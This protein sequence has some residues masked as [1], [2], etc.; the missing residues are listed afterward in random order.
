MKS[1]KIKSVKSLGINPTID[2]EV[3]HPDHN[4]YA[5]GVV[6]SNSHS[7]SYASLAATTVALKSKYPKEFLFSCL[8]MAKY[9]TKSGECITRISNELKYYGISILPPSL[10][11]SGDDFTLDGEGIRF[12]LSAINGISG[13]ALEKL[14]KLNTN[15]TNKFEFFEFAG[16]AGVNITVLGALIQSGVMSEE[17]SGPRTRLVLEAQIW[18][19][20]TPKEKV[21]CLREGEKCGYNLI[22]MVKG[23]LEWTDDNGKKV[24][25]ATRLD[26]I[27]KKYQKYKEIYL[28]NSQYEQFC[29][30]F[31][32][33]HLL[34]FAYSSSLKDV[35]IGVCPQLISIDEFNTI[36]G[37]SPK[38]TLM[39]FVTEI[40][41]G[42]SKN[43]RRY[44]RFTLEDGTGVL[45]AFVF[46]EQ[47]ADGVRTD[48]KK[49]KRIPKIGDVA[50][51]RGKKFQDI[52][53]LDDVSP[54]SEKIFVALKDLKNNTIDNTDIVQVED[55]TK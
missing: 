47:D 9:E 12:G 45:K 50:A 19:L 28:Q 22:E 23:I 43:R 36:D 54:Q 34:G 25:R 51:F 17:F 31:M 27:K 52:F 18:N 32:E 16:Q 53:I 40:T 20:L 42:K 7:L 15:Y 14:K 26:T 35:F 4:F 41:E 10:K 39:A 44:T 13:A 48:L 6:V 3:E 8:K 11:Y 46:D 33:K 38:I 37:K 29:N 49:R 24:A 55:V 21:Y 1:L 2:L 30:H 5:D